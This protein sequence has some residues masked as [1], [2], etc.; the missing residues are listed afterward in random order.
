MNERRLAVIE[1][2]GDPQKV[3]ESVNRLINWAKNQVINVKPKAG[4]AF[5]FGYDDPETTDQ[6]DFR[7]DL[8]I[9]VPEALHL[10]DVVIASWFA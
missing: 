10:D 7:F 8:G 2:R 5:G 6:A 4:D 1:H 9:A 3:G